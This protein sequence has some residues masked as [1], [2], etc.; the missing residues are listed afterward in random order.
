MKRTKPQPAPPEAD[1]E[2]PQSKPSLH[3]SVL[4]MDKTAHVCPICCEAIKD[5]TSRRPGQEA[6]LCEGSCQKW[7]HRW[8]AGVH[9]DD[10]GNLASSD[11]PFMCP[12]CS[13]AEH[14]QL[15]RSLVNTVE[16]LREEI[17]LLKAQMQLRQS[18]GEDASLSNPSIP[19]E[20]CA[21]SV[22]QTFL[23]SRS[24]SSRSPPEPPTRN[25][26]HLSSDSSNANR[27]YNIVIYGVDE[28]PECTSRHLR[29][30]KYMESVTST[31][32]SLDPKVTEHSICDSFRLGKYDS[33]RHR[34]L[35]V[36]LASVSNIL[37]NRAKLASTPGI[38]IRPDLTT[39]ERAT[40]SLL[41]KE[42]RLLIIAGTEKNIKIR[43]NS[44]L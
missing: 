38:T 1:E 30:S 44:L 2:P 19:T 6:V 27:K 16:C 28:N 23:H 43:E 17:G 8:C 36:K 32:Q 31:L 33:T 13:L 34:P 3:R 11:S 29:L 21:A 15:I 26:P 42:R 12:S 9:K 5:A 14:R 37:A 24:Q 39:Q 18:S 10:Y 20:D 41:L 7:L 35:L 40:K 22:C 25:K 4:G